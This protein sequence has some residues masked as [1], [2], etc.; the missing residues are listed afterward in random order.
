MESVGREVGRLNDFTFYYGCAS[1]SS[2]KALRVM[3]ESN[4][5]ISYATQNNKPWSGIENL[6]VDSGGYP[7]TMKKW[8]GEY[9]TSDSDYLD[10]VEKYE[11]KLFALR[12][13]PCE[14]SL[15]R[16]L[17]RTVEDHQEKTLERHINLLEER[18]ERSL[19]SEPVAVL[20]GR[21]PN[22][23]V[24]CIELFKDHSVLTDYI[25]IGTLC[26][27]SVNDVIRKVVKT[28]RNQLPDKKIHA[29]GVKGDALEILSIYRKLDSA[30]SLA[31]DDNNAT[32]PRVS[33]TQRKSFRDCVLS[34]LSMKRR[35]NRI[36]EGDVN[37]SEVHELEAFCS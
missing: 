29:F 16:D 33:G 15:L 28:V 11:P 21:S 19:K 26:G 20:Q 9:P 10:Y 31:Y 1:G 13:Y 32:F 23:Y 30:D 8:G 4:V 3:E 2:R 22:D 36:I 18:N 24:K 25:G 12:D 17:N 27:R 34:Y 5:F 35:I 7:K 6:F 37:F 14:K